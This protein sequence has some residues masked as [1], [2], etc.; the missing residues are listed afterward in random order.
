[1]GSIVVDGGKIGGD[2]YLKSTV[3]DVNVRST[4]GTN[5]VGSILVK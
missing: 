3:R 2:A 4:G 5:A 1:L